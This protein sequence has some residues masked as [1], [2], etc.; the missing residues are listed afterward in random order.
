MNTSYVVGSD[1][2]AA[3]DV[4]AL[5][6]R[7]LDFANEHSPPED[8]HALDVNGLLIP[9]ITFVSVRDPRGTVLGVGA[10][11]ELDPLHGELKSMH[12]AAEARSQ[13]VARGILMHLLD[14]AR[15]RGYERVSL[16]TG[17]GEAFTPARALYASAGF[18]VCPPFGDY[19]ESPNSTCMTLSL[20]GPAGR[21]PSSRQ[22]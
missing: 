5:L 9:A 3:A 8:V 16:E 7:H 4:Q 10:L 6:Q 22:C 12:T 14:L 2:P 1:D 21:A 19:W 20:G 18:E 13:G 15:S 11:R 17:T